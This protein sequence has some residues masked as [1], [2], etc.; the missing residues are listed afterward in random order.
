MIRMSLGYKVALILF[1]LLMVISLV[2]VAYSAYVYFA[3]YSAV[4]DFEVKIRNVEFENSQEGFVT[5]TTNFIVINPTDFELKLLYFKEFL[6]KTDENGKTAFLNENYKAWSNRNPFILHGHSNCT[7]TINIV[8]IP[9]EEIQS[10]K[11]LR[12]RVLIVLR[13]FPMLDKAARFVRWVLY[14]I[15]G[16]EIVN[17]T[18]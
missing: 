17:V 9:L 6:Y 2:I 18:Q 3:L 11:M 8:N 15:K 12:A 4:R 16:Y 10:A 5:I 13:G 1:I 14:E 7:I